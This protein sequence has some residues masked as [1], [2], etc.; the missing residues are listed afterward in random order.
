MNYEPNTRQWVRGEIVI[1][2]AD[3]KEPRMLMKVIGFTRAGLPK[4]RY[5][6]KRQSRK[7]YI[8][9]FKYLLDPTQFGLNP[10]WADHRQDLLEIYQVEWCLVRNWNLHYEVGQRVMTTSADGGFETVTVGKAYQDGTGYG[11]VRLE[12]GGQW[13]LRFVKA[14]EVIE[15]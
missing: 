13:L 6:D 14:I 9:E 7:V 10:N 8:N 11:N 3:A 2:D 1:H 4:T 5:V 12:R 15:R